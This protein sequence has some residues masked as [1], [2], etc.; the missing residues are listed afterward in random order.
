MLL[1]CFP[2][3]ALAFTLSESLLTLFRSLAWPSRK[4]DN[5][6]VPEIWWVAQFHAKGQFY[7][8]R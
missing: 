4:T 5:H 2:I 3:S 1:L 7:A 8:L 6:D